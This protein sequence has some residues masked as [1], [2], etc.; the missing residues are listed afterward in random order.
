MKN[1]AAPSLLDLAV[2][3]LAET[4]RP[5]A[6]W[7]FGSQARNQA[8]PDSDYDLLLIVSD[9]ADREHRKAD[10]AYRT[11]RSL[12]RAFDITIWRRSAFDEQTRSATSL[13]STT[14]REGRL[15][16]AA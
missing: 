10:L 6:I 5:E 3:R 13:P 8:G 12:G 7:L 9:D 14:L 4:Y 11:L 2:S 15:L 16:Y 1:P